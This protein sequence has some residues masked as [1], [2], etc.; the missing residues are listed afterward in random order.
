M[1][2]YVLNGSLWFSDA[3]LGQL[4]PQRTLGSVWTHYIVTWAGTAGI[5]RIEAR[6]AAEHPTEHGVAV[7]NKGL[8]RQNVSRTEVEKPSCG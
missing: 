3:Q 4:C 6:D 7:H 8:S 2:S 5:Q 1:I